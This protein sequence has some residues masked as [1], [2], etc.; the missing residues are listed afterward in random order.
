MIDCLKRFVLGCVFSVSAI[1]VMVPNNSAKAIN[2]QIKNYEVSENFLSVN[3]KF[4]SVSEFVEN[5]KDNHALEVE[6]DKKLLS[7]KDCII[8]GDLTKKDIKLSKCSKLLEIDLNDKN[9]ILDSGKPLSLEL[10]FKVKNNISKCDTLVNVNRIKKE[11]LKSY[12]VS[13]KGNPEVDKCRLQNLTPNV[14]NLSPSFDPN[15]FDYTLTVDSTVKS[16]EFDTSTMHEGLNVKVNRKKLLSPG[17]ETTIKISVSDPKLKIKKVY[18]VKVF[19][20]PNTPKTNVKV[21]KCSNSGTNSNCEGLESSDPDILE[22][23]SEDTCDDHNK[24]L[25]KT[26][27]FLTELQNLNMSYKDKNPKETQ[28]IPTGSDNFELFMMIGALIVILSIL[29]YIIYRK[30]KLNRKITDNP[31]NKSLKK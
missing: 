20:K 9:N 12:A 24:N 6:Y 19:R 18:R 28:E 16:V 3:L 27:Q 5:F 11:N 4:D 26:K 25:E 14:G 17:K 29:C 13:L 22:Q 7:F 8:K 21:L 2:C 15:T 1:F 23:N 31:L 30:I 10:T